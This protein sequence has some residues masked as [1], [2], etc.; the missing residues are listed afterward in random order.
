[1]CY[2]VHYGQVYSLLNMSEKSS[3]KEKLQKIK[4]IYNTPVTFLKVSF[5]I[6][7][8]YLFFTE[9]SNEKKLKFTETVL[10]F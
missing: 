10:D 2:K 9:K 6:L 8:I 7:F 3:L 1:M 5:E 4:L